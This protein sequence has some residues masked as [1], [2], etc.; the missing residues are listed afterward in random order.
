MQKLSRFSCVL[1][2]ILYGIQISSGFF[3]VKSERPEFSGSIPDGF[4]GEPVLLS[5]SVSE[6]S[7][8]FRTNSGR[9]R[10]LH[11][12][13]ILWTYKK[14][15]LPQRFLG[16]LSSSFSSLS[17]IVAPFESSIPLNPSNDSC[18]NLG[19]QERRSRS[20]TPPINFSSK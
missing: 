8:S 18:S 10:K 15:L 13:Q 19:I 2:Y 5:V 4:R 3:R 11:N 17:S 20:T 16:F 7:G 1:F 9:P 14:G 6:Y 12:G